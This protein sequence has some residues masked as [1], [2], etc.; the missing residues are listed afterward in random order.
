MLQHSLSASLQW[1]QLHHSCRT[2]QTQDSAKEKYSDSALVCDCEAVECWV[3]KKSEDL[4]T[5]S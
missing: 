5:T 3:G 1:T 2:A 4:K